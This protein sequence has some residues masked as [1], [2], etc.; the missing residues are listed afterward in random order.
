MFQGVVTESLMLSKIDGEVQSAGYESR[1]TSGKLASRSLEDWRVEA[2]QAM[3]MIAPSTRQSYGF[4]VFH[5]H[6]RLPNTWPSP[7][8]HLIQFCVMLKCS[9]LSVHSIKGKLITFVFASKITSFVENFSSCK[10]A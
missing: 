1:P 4:T 8:V 2:Y 9:G 5:K 6:E 10:N 3:S 7:V